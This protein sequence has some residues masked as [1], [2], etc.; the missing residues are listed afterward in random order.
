MTTRHSRSSFPFSCA[1]SSDISTVNAYCFKQALFGEFANKVK[2]FDHSHKFVHLIVS[3]Y[4]LQKLNELSNYLMASNWIT[5]QHCPSFNSPS[6][7]V[8]YNLRDSLL[9]CPYA[10]LLPFNPLSLMNLLSL[11][12][13][14]FP[15]WM[16]WKYLF[17]HYV[18][19]KTEN[20]YQKT[21]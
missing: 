10:V 12:P 21:F 5:S 3:Y 17:L 6:P 11:T 18:F 15:I 1:A 2:K 7:V 16:R 13:S 9:F 14:K 19:R 4:H 20:L 8:L